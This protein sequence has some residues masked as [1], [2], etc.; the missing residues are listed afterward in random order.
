[1]RRRTIGLVLAMAMCCSLLFTDRAHAFAGNEALLEGSDVKV[2]DAVM[3]NLLDYFGDLASCVADDPIP[4]I[5]TSLEELM[6]DGASEL[7]GSVFG[8]KMQL[9]Y[10]ATYNMGRAYGDL[11]EA[12]AA[13]GPARQKLLS[14]ALSL[15]NQCI[16]NLQTTSANV[17]K[18]GQADHRKGTIRTDAFLTALDIGNT[19][20]RNI[21]ASL[22]ESA[23]SPLFSFFHRDEAALIRSL[24]DKLEILIDTLP[25]PSE[26]YQAGYL[27]AQ[28]QAAQT[29]PTQPP[30]PPAQSA[31]STLAISITSGP[32]GTL[33]Q[34]EVFRVR[35]VITSNYPLSSVTT[36]VLNADG[37]VNQTKTIYPGKP[38]V[39]ILGD[40]LDTM[41]FGILAP[42]AY[43]L[44][45][46]AADGSGASAHWSSDFSIAGATAP[47][48]PEQPPETA[49]TQYRY[50]RYADSAGNV[51]V[52]AYY[53]G[54]KNGSTM[55]LQYTPWLDER[56]PMD[57]GSYSYYVHARQGELCAEKGCIDPSCDTYR[58]YMDGSY[59][60]YEETRNV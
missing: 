56:L 30:A 4:S 22:R 60:Y 26:I 47:P 33:P 10:T 51:S 49:K 32:S 44:T 53:G 6:E 40:G 59:W 58:F 20:E 7:I 54:W 36:S 50:H 25:L 39:D 29:P 1:M 24:A 27:V 35:G 5:P 31:D 8:T 42:G 9:L 48:V 13:A 2:I 28:G 46:D 52:C 55:E 21:I 38:R 41:R 45:F 18:Q 3:V 34:G 12:I 37:S 43:S 23:K 11:G 16:D 19:S 17:Y 14:A 15:G 57:N